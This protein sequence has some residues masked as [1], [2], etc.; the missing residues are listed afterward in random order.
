VL[1]GAAVY[2]LGV[3]ERPVG[4]ALFARALAALA[5]S[6]V[7]AWA[8][9][10][11]AG[12]LAR[13]ALRAGRVGTALVTADLARRP[14]VHR[15]FALLAVAVALFAT[16]LVGWDTDGRARQ[17]RAELA[18]G[19][20]RVLTVRADGRAHLI[21]AVR[22]ADPGGRAAMAVV[23]TGATLAVDAPRLAA[24]ALWRPEYGPGAA[25]VARLLHPPAPDPIRVSGSGLEL[26]AEVPAGAT[27]SALLAPVRSGEPLAVPF[28]APATGGTT[29]VAPAP[30]CAGPGG[31]RLIGFRLGRS[32]SSDAAGE[33][34]PRAVL[35]ELRQ[36][37]PASTL[38]DSAGF[39]DR[40]R[41]RPTSAPARLGPVL[42]VADGGS[43]LSA[44]VVGS[45]VPGVQPSGEVYTVDAPVP[46][47]VVVAGAL[48]EPDLAGDTR[49]NALGAQTV[50]ARRVGGAALLP[51]LGR[52]GALVDLEYLDRVGS[53]TLGDQTMQVWL[54]RDAGWATVDRLVAAGLSVLA[55]DSA[56]A[57]AA[58]LG[59]QGPA[60]GLRFQLLVAALGMLLAAGAITVVA[61]VER[62]A[63]ATELAALRAQGLGRRAI[64]VVTVA[65]PTVLAGLAILAGLA[66]AAVAGAVTRSTGPAFA[67]GWRL[68]DPPGLGAVAAGLALA[69]PA[70]VL[71]G[72]AAVAGLVLRR[73]VRRRARAGLP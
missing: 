12:G 9:V 30:A 70:V 37:G 16:A 50:P 59:R 10:P 46:L 11:L 33:G 5:V 45:P 22:A 15:I 64:R 38:V 72:A 26:T 54:A 47:P 36:T 23:R 57:A 14:G 3:G 4:L 71:G 69:V 63:R 25:A 62:P 7:L 55:D 28:T 31:C 58:R 1:A 51:V 35:R 21:A 73:A 18:T 60:V 32:G 17:A 68:P 44:R 8:V 20:A 19:A 41:W 24:T 53:A 67:D 39:A 49:L 66:A 29:L 65:G 2:Q 56:E 40:A 6:L 42:A 13:Y 61:A 52:V 43:G 34:E 48:P 27:V